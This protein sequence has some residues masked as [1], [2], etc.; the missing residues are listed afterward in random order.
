M[1]ASEPTSRTN[2]PR[3]RDSPD[4]WRVGD[5]SRLVEL[6][7]WFGGMPMIE[8]PADLSPTR[9]PRDALGHSYPGRPV[10]RSRRLQEAS[11]IYHAASV[12]IQAENTLHVTQFA[13]RLVD[14]FVSER[15][16]WPRSWGEL[17]GRV[18]CAVRIRLVR[19]GQQPRRRFSV[20]SPSIS[21]SIRE[22]WLARTHEFHRHP[23]DRPAL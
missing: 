17:A 18:E 10:P 8:N 6:I 12:S 20:E 23:A 16:R 1:R 22:T 3:K 14:R 5:C 21:A 7:L 11:L 4:H 19:N 15:G 9:D 2:R 13:I